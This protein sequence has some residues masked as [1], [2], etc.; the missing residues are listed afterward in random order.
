MTGQMRQENTS[1]TQARRK[2]YFVYGS[3]TTVHLQTLF[4]YVLTIHAQRSET[5]LK[6]I[7]INFRFDTRNE[8]DIPA[9]LMIIMYN[10]EIEVDICTLLILVR[11]YFRFFM[12]L[13]PCVVLFVISPRMLFQL[14]C[15]QILLICTLRHDRE[16]GS[17]GRNTNP[18]P[19]G[20]LKVNKSKDMKCRQASHNFET[21]L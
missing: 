21:A 10:V 2:T 7:Q 6:Y 4:W 11:C 17:T 3:H 1:F 18:C 16:P 9:L 19:P 14:S 12:S 5:Y 15:C 8:G 13:K 20:C